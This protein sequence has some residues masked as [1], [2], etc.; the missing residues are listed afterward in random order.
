MKFICNLISYIVIATT[1][2]GC[3]HP[4]IKASLKTKDFLKNQKLSENYG[5]EEIKLIILKENN[6]LLL[7]ISEEWCSPCR[8]MEG[9]LITIKYGF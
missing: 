8:A 6:M 3:M 5:N 4:G 7:S 1:I 9:T 2:F